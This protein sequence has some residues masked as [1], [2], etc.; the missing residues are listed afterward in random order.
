MVVAATSIGT[1]IEQATNEL[2]DEIRRGYEE[3][4]AQERATVDYLIESIADL[5]R[6]LHEPGWV[7]A[8]A[9]AQE[10]FSPEG[11][12]QMRAACRL[13]ALKNPLIKRGLSL[14]AAYVWGRGVE[15]TARAQGRLP[16]EQDVQAVISAMLNDPANQRAVTGSQAREALE[17]F[18]LGTD[19]EVF[20]AAIAR[21]LTGD[22]QLRTISPDEITDIITDP[23]DA[24]TPWFYRK[25]TVQSIVDMDTGIRRPVR[26]VVWYPAIHYRPATRRATIGGDRVDWSTRI[27][28][29][30]ANRPPRWLRGIPDAYAAIDWAR[31]YNEFLTDWARLMKSLSRFA[32]RTTIPSAKAG[33]ATRAAI[34]AAP[35]RSPATGE[36]LHAGATAILPPNAMLEA[37]PK[38][39]ATLDAD[40]GRPI[41]AMVA[42][43]LGVPVTML[44]GDPGV[45]GARATAE[46]LDQPTELE[47]GLRR[48]LWEWAYRQLIEFAILEAVRAPQGKLKGK[49]IRDPFTGKEW[50]VLDG[51]N[52]G[53]TSQVV[54][55]VWP[56]LDDTDVA[57][58][59][60][61]IVEASG[62]G[63]IPPEHVLR[64]LLS[65][66]GVT[67]VDGILEKMID[68][69]TGK[70]IWPEGPP[71]GGRDP[72][73]P[74]PSM[75]PDPDPD[76]DGDDGEA[77]EPD[78]D[79]GDGDEGGQDGT[80]PD[81]EPEDDEGAQQRRR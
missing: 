63:T 37:I 39:G 21:P 73:D 52:G 78:G 15:I 40:S 17:R 24:E 58:T 31:A 18:G 12:R 11:L 14:R 27:L 32:W 75:R 70:F 29:V 76:L 26:T 69:E 57:A 56:D 35:S 20:I 22:V 1:R 45:T 55:F 71:L 51:P 81:D 74:G 34:A 10:E 19:G 60:K 28:H 42:A 66:L 79:Q 16:G 23:G 6:D 48:Q 43:A 64:L 72:L 4:L 38:S 59:V 77:D 50:A 7:R 30:T 65:A 13:Y 25:E 49:I 5:E 2:I 33:A 8:I 62:T 80:E 61:A 46:T 9:L 53:E 36:P 47:T 44:L 68:P 67:D 54:D 41:A 3:Q